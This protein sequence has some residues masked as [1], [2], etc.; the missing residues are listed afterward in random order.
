MV[1]A[2]YKQTEVG[3]IPEEWE[4]RT[5][6]EMFRLINGC[7]FKPADWKK[8]GSPIIRIQNLN[9]P[10]AEF[11]FSQ[12]PV[13]ERNRIVAGDL[14]FAWSGTLGSSFG[15]RVWN[16]PSGVLNQHIFKV[17]MDERQ[18]M[19]PFSVL[20][21]ARVEED[22]AKQAHGFKASFV[23]VKKSDLVKVVLPLP[24]LPEQQAIATTISDADELVES[25][26]Q[27]LTKKRQIKQGAMQELLT[28]KKR[29]HGFMGEW[30]VKSLLDLAEGRK[31]FF[32][33][34]DWIESEHIIDSGIRLIQTGNVGVGGYVE[35]E[36]KKY[37]SEASFVTLRCK[38]VNPGDLL[39]CRLADPAGRA[40][41]LPEIGEEK[42]VT[43][44]DV[45]IFRP[46]IGTANRVFLMNL[47]STR[48]WFGEVSEKSG[49]T[50]HKRISRGALGRLRILIPKIPEQTAIAEI[51]SDMDAEISAHETKL[52]KARQVKQGMMQELL[53]G[54]IRLV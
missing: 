19:L 21:F 50:T 31:D 3:L 37:I 52:T 51:L 27:L 26:E 15:A 38:Q 49:G 4:L 17:L 46:P 54:R 12:I 34:G 33:D 1:K 44:V 43:S 9:D 6:G 29:L 20:V 47:F 35:T 53:T 28:G 7:A 48:Q 11:N 42:I 39:I 41:V 14:L 45:T 16:G 30:E 18:I 36:I 24:P 5:I 23:H 10:S 8:S 2:G 32:D 13:Q 25:L 22:I 40:C